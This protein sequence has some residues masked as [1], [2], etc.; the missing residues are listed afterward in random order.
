[1][2]SK[3]IKNF[4]TWNEEMAKKYNPDIKAHHSPN[5]VIRL[6]ERT[7]T[8]RIIDFL[9][10]HNSDRIIDLGCGAGNIMERIKFA[11][12]IVG[13]D[14]SSF[15]L[16][17]AKKRKYQRPVRFIKTN[18]EKLSRE[19]ADSKFDKIYCSET[20]EHVENPDKVLKEIKKIAKKNSVI[21][22]SIPNENLINKIKNILQKIRLFNLIFPDMP[23]KMDEEWHLHSFDLIKLKEMTRR[24]YVI[25]KIKRIPFCI[26]P[27]RYVVKLGLKK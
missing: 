3:K 21:V 13:V 14:L 8:K 24:D 1:M 17:L 27:L 26:L 7:R 11:K 10:P 18:I 4:E 20:L 2:I 9:N 6:I 25:K 16:N 5:L 19:I 12:E 22:I 15:L 23:V